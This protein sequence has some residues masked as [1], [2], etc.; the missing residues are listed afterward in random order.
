MK[1]ERGFD[2]RSSQNSQ[3]NLFRQRN[4]LG[5]LYTSSKSTVA[6]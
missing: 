2:K 4:R 3:V 6:I 1:T 5:L